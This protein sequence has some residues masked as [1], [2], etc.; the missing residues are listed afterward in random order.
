MFG[1]E[2]NNSI[3]VSL[4]GVVNSDNRNRLTDQAK[5]NG[6]TANVTPDYRI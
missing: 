5:I 4:M 3:P 1:A 2:E 6:H